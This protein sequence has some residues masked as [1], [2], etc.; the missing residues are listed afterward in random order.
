VTDAL[1]GALDDVT[2][3]RFEAHLAECL[4]CRRYLEQIRTTIDLL[5]RTPRWELSPAARESVLEA[6]RARSPG[7]PPAAG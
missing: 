5:A 4:G 1:D 2:R 3:D 6:F 7:R